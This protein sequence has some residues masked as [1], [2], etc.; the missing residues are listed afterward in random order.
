VS[1]K[2]TRLQVGR[3]VG[4]RGLALP[5][6]LWTR[7]ASRFWG[8]APFVVSA[9]FGDALPTSQDLFRIAVDASDAGAPVRL[10]EERPRASVSG[11]TYAS[12]IQ[13]PHEELPRADDASFSAYR[14][15]FR[16][17][18]GGIHFGLVV[19]NLIEH[20]WDLW[21]RM[22]PFL[23]PLYEAVGI[24]MGGGLL[25]LWCG[26]YLNTPFGIHKDAQHVFTFVI[27][28]T[29]R[30][31][32]WPFEYFARRRDLH[33]DA[34]EDPLTLL[35]TPA[36]YAHAVRDAIEVEAKPGD[37]IYWPPSYWHVAK[38][39]GA[40]AM[41]LAWGFL[42]APNAVE[43]SLSRLPGEAPSRM[44]VR[45][46]EVGRAGEAPLPA[47]LARR[48][49]DAGLV[50]S[51]RA[52]RRDAGLAWLRFVT[53]LGV[54][55]M[56]ASLPFALLSDDAIVRGAPDTPV[57]W[58]AL[59]RN[60]YAIGANGHAMAI[61]ADPS[62]LARVLDVL[63]RI[64]RGVPVAVATLLAP[65]RGRHLASRDVVRDLLRVLGSWRALH[66]PIVRASPSR[67]G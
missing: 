14:R 47:A 20:S 35:H 15:R 46:R 51:R 4:D 27:D 61:T 3:G 5:R 56:P 9:P 39:S 13:A 53:G 16:R 1:K 22:R 34:R 25:D 26:D 2:V 10:Y 54:L 58:T 24:P 28:G 6:G 55:K 43:R 23:P 65:F 11:A 12:L 37:L 8:R 18:H 63:R 32:L 62:I 45:A 50:R 57:A 66:G 7:I 60:E 64:N 31:Y 49:K 21:H 48:I 29:K 38:G 41:T 19:D 33:D 52:A 17:E 42:T 67:A 36:E 30:F 59:A 44:R 40:F